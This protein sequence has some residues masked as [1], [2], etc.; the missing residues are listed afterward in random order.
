MFLDI[1]KITIKILI[2]I[3]EVSKSQEMIK[4]ASEYGRWLRAGYPV[5]FI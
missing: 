5:Y 3:D 4:F 2:G 1:Q